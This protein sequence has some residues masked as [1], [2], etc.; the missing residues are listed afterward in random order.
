MSADIVI[1]KMTSSPLA[2]KHKEWSE[3]LSGHDPNSIQNQIDALLSDFAAYLVINYAR[4]LAPKDA[5]G[6]PKVSPLLHRL[7]DRTF[8]ESTMVRIRKLTEARQCQPKKAVHSLV[9]LLQDM[10]DHP[11]LLTRENILRCRHET[12]DRL[13]GTSPASRLPRDA[14]PPDWFKA[15]ITRITKRS[16][17][18]K[19]FVNK[20]L[21]HAATPASR[22][23]VNSD[24]MK[25]HL[26]RLWQATA[27]IC[28]VAHQVDVEI[29]GGCACEPL[30]PY[31]PCEFKY[32][33]VEPANPDDI[34]DLQRFWER[35]QQKVERW[36][37]VRKLSGSG[38]FFD[39]FWSHHSQTVGDC[40]N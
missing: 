40:G 29:L 19:N 31:P 34:Q 14:I 16:R 2:A 24:E 25:V 36:F 11:H 30:G 8:A 35:V 5:D 22:E 15:R 7:L 1:S 18:V 3:A 37:G 13:A 17:N 38:P 4:G 9:A 39:W 33:L 21:A 28:K 6:E 32:L 10:H 23:S 12:I 27:L 26:A 20:F